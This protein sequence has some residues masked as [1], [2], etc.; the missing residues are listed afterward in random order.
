MSTQTFRSFSDPTSVFDSVLKNRKFLK[1]QEDHLSFAVSLYE[2]G[3]TEI[4]KLIALKK[5][6]SEEIIIDSKNRSDLT[7]D[8]FDKLS[9][10]LDEEQIEVLTRMFNELESLSYSCEESAYVEGFFE[11]YKYMKEL[12][13][14]AKYNR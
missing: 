14:M 11:G 7:D 13:E 5:F 10:L 1:K 6:R 9:N 12:W 4:I 8:L 2:A 3:M